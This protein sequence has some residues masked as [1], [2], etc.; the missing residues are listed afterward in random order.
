MAEK[1]RGRMDQTDRLRHRR[2][3]GVRSE[4]KSSVSGTGG[5]ETVIG[6]R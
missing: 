2:L 5:G 6:Q 1:G 4:G 3:G